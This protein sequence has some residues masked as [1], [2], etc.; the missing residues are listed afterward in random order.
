MGMTSYFFSSYFVLQV[1]GLEVEVA[2]ATVF[3]KQAWMILMVDTAVACPISEF[4]CWEQPLLGVCPG[5]V[6]PLELCMCAPLLTSP[7][8]VIRTGDVL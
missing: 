5:L 2:R 4:M 3:Y 7:R 1:Q 6:L 8:V